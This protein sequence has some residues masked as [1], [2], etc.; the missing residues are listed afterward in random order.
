M[1][2]FAGEGF[3]LSANV[4]CGVF[5]RIVSPE[6]PGLSSNI[7]Q[8]IYTPELATLIDGN[9]FGHQTH[10]AFFHAGNGIFLKKLI[11]KT[12]SSALASEP[13]NRRSKM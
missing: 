6:N 2:L 3:A 12:C 8:D 11:W 4:L 7:P 9:A 10:V 5:A 1:L 13:Y